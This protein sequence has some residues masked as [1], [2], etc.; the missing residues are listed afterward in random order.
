MRSDD[1]GPEH[2]H[3]PPTVVAGDQRP[4]R[5]GVG[6]RISVTLFGLDL[7]TVEVDTSHD[8]DNGTDPGDC[9]SMPLGFTPSPG[10]QRWQSSPELE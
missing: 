6:M 1:L 9:T 4:S 10:D 3:Q 5:L 8:S 2:I 7:L